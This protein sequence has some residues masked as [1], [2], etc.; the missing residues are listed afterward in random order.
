[1]LCDQVGFGSY[2]SS[3]VN[4]SARI[5]NGGISSTVTYNVGTY[6]ITSGVFRGSKISWE[7]FFLFFENKFTIVQS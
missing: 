7:L 5:P 4:I 3:V 2:F 6:L 1:M